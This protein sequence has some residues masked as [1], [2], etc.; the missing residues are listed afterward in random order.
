MYRRAKTLASCAPAIH[1]KEA[2]MRATKPQ[3]SPKECKECKEEQRFDRSALSDIGISGSDEG[4][5]APN[6]QINMQETKI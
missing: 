5:R 1:K 2:V 3:D 6:R 4:Y